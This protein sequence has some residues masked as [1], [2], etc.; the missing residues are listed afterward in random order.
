M[1]GL[2]PIKKLRVFWLTAWKSPSHP[3]SRAH[4]CTHT[5]MRHLFNFLFYWLVFDEAAERTPETRTKKK[6]RPSI[7]MVCTLFP[8]WSKVARAS[9]WKNT[10]SRDAPLPPCFGSLWASWSSLALC[11]S[12]WF[13]LVYLSPVFS[14]IECAAVK[15]EHKHEC[16]SH[17]VW[18]QISHFI[19]MQDYTVVGW[20]IHGHV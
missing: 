11:L 18:T 15:P 20:I 6:W 2:T 14:F 8:R 4:T 17:L 13:E 19:V 3:H 9:E 7:H 12:K 5:H 16:L 1:S 10:R